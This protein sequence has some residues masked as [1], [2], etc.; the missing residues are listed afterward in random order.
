MNTKKI[1]SAAAAAAMV[2]AFAGISVSAEDTI[3]VLVTVSDGDLKLVQQEVIVSD[4]NDDGFFSI[5]EALRAAHDQYFEGGAE[6]G[7]ASVDSD[8]GT[9]L[10][11]LWGVENGGMY[12]YYVNS[13]MAM[14]LDDNVLD[15][16]LIDAWVYQDTTGFSDKYTY[17]DKRSAE[18]NAGSELTLVLCGIEFDENY[19]PVSVPLAN[20]EITINGEGTGIMTDEEGRADITLPDEEGSYLISAS[21]ADAIIVPP[22]SMA[23]V[24]AAEEEAPAED[25]EDI[26][27]E[28]DEDE[29]IDEA[30]PEADEEAAPAED[31]PEEAA[32]APD[33]ATESPATGNTPVSVFI[34]FISAATAAASAALAMRRKNKNAD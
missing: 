14:S 33:A 10:A 27:P 31:E 12:G 30:A 5:D 20:A 34:A 15:G 18:Q 19:A 17:F 16:D 3:S 1:I 6:A 21:S 29:D 7:Y 24:S 8:Y 28:P 25:E 32:P 11:K 9:S 22:V 2:S 26:T 13:N 23:E 4:D